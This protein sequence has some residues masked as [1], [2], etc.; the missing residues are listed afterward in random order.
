MQPRNESEKKKEKEELLLCTAQLI[1]KVI[2]LSNDFAKN[3][4]EIRFKQI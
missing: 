2:R 4:L 3:S 1:K